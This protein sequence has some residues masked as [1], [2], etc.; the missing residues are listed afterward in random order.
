MTLTDIV[1]RNLRRR[2]G[3]MALIVGCLAIGVATVVALRALTTAIEQEVGAQLDQYGANIVVVPKSSSQDV[4]YGGV[5]ISTATFDVHPLRAADIGRIRSIAYSNRLSIVAPKLLGS[6]EAQ[7]QSAYIYGVDFAEELRMKKWWQISGRAP[8]SPDEVLL[9]Y[10]AAQKLGAIEAPAARRH[11][12]HDHSQHDH[13]Q[14]AAAGA[15]DMGPRR[16]ELALGDRRFRIAGVLHE[17][18]GQDDRFIYT[19]LGTAQKLLGK[20]DEL[21]LI[22]VSAL[23][24]GCPIDDIV[25]QIGA[26]LP[27]AKVS[28]VQQAVRARLQTVERLSRFTAAISAVMLLIGSLMV[29]ITMMASVV[30]RTREIGVLRAVGFRKTHVLK[31]FV[32]EAAI[33]SFAGGLLGW[34]IGTLSGVLSAPHFTDTGVRAAPSLTLA[35]AVM[36]A[37]TLIGVGSSLYPAV[38]ASRLDP[39]ESLR[40]F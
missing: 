5:S 32:I 3:R 26:K 27:S 40:Y 33:V 4:S 13:S 39:T 2:K 30:E 24:N 31:I 9:G 38:K 35:L 8:Q 6:V 25:A 37:A 23:C 16:A 15:G 28:A 11:V 20:P 22:E 19:Q 10:E 1:L 34:G 29:F 7:G 12:N 17:T 18:G 21:S 14:H 36:A